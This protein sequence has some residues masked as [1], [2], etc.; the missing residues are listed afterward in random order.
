MTMVTRNA[1]D[2]ELAG[3]QVLNPFAE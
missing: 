1:R 2:F 3:V